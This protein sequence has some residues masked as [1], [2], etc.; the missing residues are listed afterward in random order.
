MTCR[1]E[2]FPP[3]VIRVY[4]EAAAE[5]GACTAMLNYYRGILRGGGMRRIT[6][7]GFPVIDTPTLLIWGTEDPVLLPST[8]DDAHQFLKDM[9]LRFIP[10][11]GHWVQQEAPEE[12][13][14]IL[15]AWLRG[16]PVP[17]VA[18]R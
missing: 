3:D 5:P 13:N 12:V 15:A 6:K 7:R 17:E 2:R 16:E 1:K 14:P 4:K 9:T 18:A 10:R 8:L 11:A